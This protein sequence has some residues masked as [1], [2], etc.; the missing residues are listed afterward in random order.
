M[1]D[2]E[3]GTRKLGRYEL[4][5]KLD[6]D[7]LSTVYLGRTAGAEGFSRPVTVKII[8]DHLMENEYARRCFVREATLA[9]RLS[10]PNIVQVLDFAE[11]DGQYLMVLEYVHGYELGV[12]ARYLADSGRP[13]QLEHAFFVVH[14][15]LR[16][17]DFAH[18]LRDERGEL[19][20]MAHCDIT[21]DNVLLSLSGQVKLS[22]FG[23]AHVRDEITRHSRFDVRGA[24][25]YQ[26]PEQVTEGRIDRRSD[27]FAVGIVLFEILTGMS[28]F[29][30]K[31]EAETVMNVHRCQLPDLSALRPD[32][33]VR[34][35][36]VVSK[37][38]R[39]D[40]DERYQR[41]SEFAADLREML[42]TAS[43]SSVEPQFRKLF[44][45]VIA[46]P[47]FVEVTPPLFDLQR[48][49]AEAERRASRSRRPKTSRAPAQTTTAGSSGWLLGAVIGS[50]TLLA[51]LTIF[52]LY[53]AG[54]P[55]FIGLWG[56]DGRPGELSATT[57]NERLLSRR[58]AIRQCVRDQGA[59]A[60]SDGRVEVQVTIAADGQVTAVRIAPEAVDAS[61]FG[62]CLSRVARE[63]S[64]P[65]HAGSQRSFTVPI[66]FRSAADDS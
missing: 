7:G 52:L 18:D 42:G 32:L 41:A 39:R 8:H 29:Q 31:S 53:L 51:V 50:G 19:L 14:E 20:E 27:L 1:T 38:L 63:T 49:L 2:L 56:G 60:T 45:A 65:A 23:V 54:L 17:L 9:G 43:P 33:P 16:A 64:F 44:Q 15:L 58:E 57:V 12:F 28:L 30:G 46:E 61:A 21:P 48:E 10:H 22:G 66:F 11:E 3:L 36:D 40:P 13:M 35:V 25:A 47:A 5:R 34:I 4:I 62:R 24:L 6:R 55:G 37:A 26:A 59:P